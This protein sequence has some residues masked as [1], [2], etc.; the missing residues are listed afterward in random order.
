VASAAKQPQQTAAFQARARE[1]FEQKT[2]LY[3]W[4]RL[5]GGARPGIELFKVLSGESRVTYAGVMMLA[6]REHL[7]RYVQATGECFCD[8]QAATN[9]MACW[10]VGQVLTIKE[11]DF[12]AMRGSY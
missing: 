4:Q 12:K 10:H 7:V 1:L 2:V 11:R 8:C 3:G 9:K 5:Q 6:T